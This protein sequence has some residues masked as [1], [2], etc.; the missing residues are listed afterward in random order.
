MTEESNMVAH[1]RRELEIIG[2]EPETIRGYLNVIQAF[3]DMGPSGGM[4]MVAIPVINKLLLQKNLAPLTDDPS[5]WMHHGT[6][7]WPDPDGLGIWQNVRDSEC[8][9]K[10]AG[11]TYYIL[12]EVKKYTDVKPMHTSMHKE[13]A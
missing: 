7:V 2:E 3:A 6:D 11:K 10:D 12:S 13:A 8:F 1:A 5:E 4:A 9:S